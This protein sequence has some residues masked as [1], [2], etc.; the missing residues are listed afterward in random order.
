LKRQ[1]DL[2][3]ISHYKTSQSK[4]KGFIKEV[5]VGTVIQ[6]QSQRND[7]RQAR[8]DRL[9]R[10]DLFEQYRALRTQGLSER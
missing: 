7:A 2:A 5:A 3:I 10:A 9:E 1:G 6:S 8:W 4:G